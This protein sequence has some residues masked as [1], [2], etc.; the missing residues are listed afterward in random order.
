ME[1]T[2]VLIKP[3]AMER[4]LMGEII[5]VYEK[6]YLHITAMK[7]IRPTIKIS[8]EHYVEH[9]EKP[10][11]K[12]LIDYITRGEV[13]ALIIEGENA[14]EEV[15]RLNGA[16]DPKNAEPSSIRGR[17]ALSKSENSVHA[18]DSRESAE[19]EIKIWFPV[20]THNTIVKE[21]KRYRHFKGNEYLVLYMA[22]H[23]ETEE[24]MVV[25]QA[26]YG[27][28]GIWVRPLS[29]FLEKIER[30]GKLINRFEEIK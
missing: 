5:S 21:G 28:R 30:D 23:S 25:Y 7:I 10:F 1:R 14:V 27:E 11:F 15:R 6:S 8:E 16:T 3:D 19:R 24:D 29:M 9:K 13:C 22:K 26:L 12:E 20:L 4:K 2:L 17:F 18:S